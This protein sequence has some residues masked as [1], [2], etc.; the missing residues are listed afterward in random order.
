MKYITV[1]NDTTEED[2]QRQY[3]AWAKKLHPDMGGNQQ[4]FNTLQEEMNQA[5]SMINHSDFKGMNINEIKDIAVNAAKKHFST[6]VSSF[7]DE[8]G[9]ELKKRL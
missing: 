3:R 1:N 8:L 2:L 5:S 9:T 6:M 4:D 7:L